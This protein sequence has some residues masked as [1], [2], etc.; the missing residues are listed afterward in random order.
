MA[1]NPPSP[2]KTRTSFQDIQ[3]HYDVSDEFF[4]LFQ[5]ATRTYSCAYFEPPGISLEEAQIAKVD[6]NLDQLDLK[7]GMTLLDIGCGWGTT[8]KRAVE[9]YD[10]NVVGLTLSNNQHARAQQVLESLDT[11]RS[12]RVLLHGWEDFHE[13]VD[14]I[15]SIEAFEHFGHENYDDF[16][17][18]CFDIMPDDGRMTVQSSVSYHPYNLNARGKKLTFETMRFIKFIITE[19][20]P[21]GRLPTTEMMVE[22]GEKAGFVVPEPVSLRPHYI[23]TLRIWGDNL[24]ANRDEAISIT[25]EEVYDRYMKYLR[26]CEHYFDDE[27][28]DV[29]LVTYL[30]PAAAA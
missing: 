20:F 5:D 6:L 24:E 12:R 1:E 4:G 21:G 14:R 9:K 28:L 18:R 3:A 10:V 30:K 15:V 26:G 11:N 23:K 13:P 27:M 17:K 25:S 22:H 7:P 19:I 29:S 16:F 2:T 8:M